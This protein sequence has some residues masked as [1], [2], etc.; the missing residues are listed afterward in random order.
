[1]CVLQHESVPGL[2]VDIWDVPYRLNRQLAW[3]GRSC[4][5]G[6]SS[7][8]VFVFLQ[9]VVSSFNLGHP[10]EGHLKPKKIYPKGGGCRLTHELV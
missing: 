8:F 5:R 4:L 3:A 10:R 9:E 2:L 1:M 7:G 6:G